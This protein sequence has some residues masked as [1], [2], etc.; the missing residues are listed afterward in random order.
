MSITAKIRDTVQDPKKADVLC[1]F[2]HP[3]GTKRPPIDTDYYE[4]FNK[5]NVSVVS[6]RKDPIREITTDAIVLEN[7]ERYKLDTIVF[8]T[9]FDAVTGSIIRMNLHGKK[10]EALSD[11]WVR[12]P[13][14]YLG[15]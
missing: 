4:T 9:G 2:N 10:G 11:K 7:G 8:A 1:E 14:A 5:D 13:Q 12:G 6:I 3:A 15:L